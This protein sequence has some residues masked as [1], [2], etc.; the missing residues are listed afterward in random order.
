MVHAVFVVSLFSIAT[1]LLAEEPMLEPIKASA[2][3]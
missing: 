1:D 2:T 3:T